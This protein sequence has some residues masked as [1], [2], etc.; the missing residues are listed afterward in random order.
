MTNIE[1][2]K[3]NKKNIELMSK[4]PK[5]KK[6]TRSWFDLAFKHYQNGKL[7]QAEILFK[8]IL[9]IMTNG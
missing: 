3:E 2:E 5:L 9:G 7:E 1:F 6:M 8:K 4:D